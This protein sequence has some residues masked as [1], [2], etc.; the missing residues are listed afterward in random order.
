[1][2]LEEQALYDLEDDVR[3]IVDRLGNLEHNIEG[4]LAR[5]EDDVKRI[6]DLLQKVLVEVESAPNQWLEASVRLGN[7]E[8]KP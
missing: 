7:L 3:R 4:R 1:M 6:A 8:N 2:T 5:V